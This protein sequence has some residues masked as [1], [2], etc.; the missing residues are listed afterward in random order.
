MGSF[1]YYSFN[2]YTRWKN[3]PVVLG[4]DEKMADISE[5]PFPA[6]RSSSFLRGNL[7]RISEIL[8]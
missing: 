3:Y 5:I 1:T 7:A 6:V 8:I 4:F 2:T